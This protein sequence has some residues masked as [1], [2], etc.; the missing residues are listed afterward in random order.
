MSASSVKLTREQ[1]YEEVWNTPIHR[2]SGKYG[3][4][5]VGLAKACKRMD[6]PRPPRGHWR[7]KEVGAKV[8]KTPL[9]KQKEGTQL[10]ITFASLSDQPKRGWKRGARGYQAPTPLLKIAES[11]REPH[12]LVDSSKTRLEGLS[13]NKSGLL[14]SKAKR[15]LDIS[16]SR[17]H[18][19][20]S[21]RLLD[22]V[23]KDWEGRGN[24]VAIDT[25][26]D[27]GATILRAGEEE[28]W[29]SI[30]EEVK[31]FEIEPT[32]E[33]SLRPKWTWK[34]RSK[35]RPTGKLTVSLS[36]NYIA[37]GRTFHRR[38]RD[39]QDAPIEMKGARI[40]G[41]TLQ[42]IEQRKAHLEEKERELEL[43]R[44]R[45]R[46]WAIEKKKEEEKARKREQKRMRLEEANRRA[47]KLFEDSERWAKAQRLRDFIEARRNKLAAEM[48]DP[49]MEEWVQWATQIADEVDPLCRDYPLSACEK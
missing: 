10:E 3:L 25:S 30:V 44:E 26:G 38:Y 5:D 31:E 22:A 19:D 4:S 6:I 16:V 18:L 14:I 20:R 32:E 33:E 23:F 40:I 8:R 41:A 37:K 29:L 46:N 36:G 24:S 9:P 21:L 34:K 47:E 2:L 7:R 1:L 15:C 12:P 13:E 45:Q 39:G 49:K 28:V 48:D 11:L 43:W 17:D 42:Y 27:K 35:I